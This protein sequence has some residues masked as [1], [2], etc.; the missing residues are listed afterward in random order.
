[1]LMVLIPRA[2]AYCTTAWPTV[3]AALFWM[4]TSPSS[5]STKSVNSR[6]AVPGATMAAE[7]T[8]SLTPVVSTRVTAARSTTAW[9]RQVP[10]P[11]AA[12]TTKSSLARSATPDPVDSTLPRPS[13]PA[14]PV[15]PEA[16]KPLISWKSLGV[17]GAATICT[18]TWLAFKSSDR[19]SVATLRT[20]CGAPKRSKRTSLASIAMVRRAPAAT[21]GRTAVRIRAAI[22]SMWWEAK[23]DKVGPGT[24]HAH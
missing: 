1:M 19:V 18:N 5:R 13:L 15:E 10:K 12:G 22:V 21:N 3:L 16:L 8:S 14:T 11:A 9:V 24:S 2:A 4:M 20:F 17:I 23:P 7:A 6:C